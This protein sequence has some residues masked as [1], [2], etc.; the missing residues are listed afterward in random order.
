[1]P[2]DEPAFGSNLTLWGVKDRRSIDLG[3]GNS[4]IEDQSHAA[5]RPASEDRYCP[6]RNAPA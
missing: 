3:W 5:T 4:D 1:M 2:M 6:V